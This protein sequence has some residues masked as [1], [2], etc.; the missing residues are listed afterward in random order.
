VK[1][2]YLLSH[3]DYSAAGKQVSLL[4]PALRS[5][6]AVIDVHVAGLGP[7]G[8]M[9]EPLRGAGVPVHALGGGPAGWW[10]LR[11]LVR[12]MRP[13]VVHAWRLPAARAAAALARWGWPPLSVVISEPR[14]G[15]R[16]NALDR[17]LG[18]TSDRS[19]DLPPVV[20][21]PT[22]EPPPLEVPLPPGAFVIMC[23]GKLTPEHGFRDAIWAA[24]VLQHSV[25]QLQLVIVGDGPELA[26]L[27][28]FARGINVEGRYTHFLS[29]RPDAA[30]L[31]AR[32][33]IVWVPGRGASGRQVALEAMAAGRPVVATARPELPAPLVDGR[34]GLLAP[35]H[36]PP[37][38]ARQTRRLIDDAD[39]AARIGAAARAA[40]APFSPDRVAPIY[41]AHYLG[42][43]HAD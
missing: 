10:R 33:D 24:D 18:I 40:V 6:P 19:C 1:L 28:R 21:I 5:H 32:A 36:S 35:P 8:P 25:P 16:P 26:R 22:G 23:V 42:V 31:L 3:F 41:A 14:R 13:D 9:T 30:P 11:R 15:G 12:E 29:G 43:R 17:L 20:A 38:L 39:F 27:Q 7:V 34:T 37:E 2:L 4:A